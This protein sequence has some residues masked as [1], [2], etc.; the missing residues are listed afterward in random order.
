MLLSHYPNTITSHNTNSIIIIRKL[1]KL[2][3]SMNI[4]IEMVGSLF[5]ICFFMSHSNILKITLT[6]V[7]N[8]KCAT[9]VPKSQT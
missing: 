9:I 1:A 7:F 6:F 5:I 4:I 3:V 2:V 8:D